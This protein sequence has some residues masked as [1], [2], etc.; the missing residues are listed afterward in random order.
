MIRAPFNSDS[1]HSAQTPPQLIAAAETIRLLDC[2][3]IKRIDSPD[4][5]LPPLHMS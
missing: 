3:A 5:A 4:S 2:G 1:P